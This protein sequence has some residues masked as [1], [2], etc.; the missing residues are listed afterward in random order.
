MCYQREYKNYGIL[1]LIVCMIIFGC[2][3]KSG[4]LSSRSDTQ[5]EPA[6]GSD[7][8][9]EPGVGFGTVK[10]RMT[11]DEVIKQLG[12][13]ERIEEHG[14][15]KIMMLYLSKGLGIYV[16]KENGVQSFTF[17]TQ[18]MLPPILKSND[19]KGTTKEGIGIGSSEAQIE[20]AYGKPTESSVQ[21]NRK[22]LDYK[23]LGINFIMLSD[24]VAQFTIRI[25]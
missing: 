25:P 24:K 2:K 6:S 21:S 20:A 19:F 1:A 7:M 13:P 8:Q 15:D 23:T 17:T 3:K 16:F 5:I 12:K 10:F 9:V 4:Y 11:E 18:E 22:T 14:G